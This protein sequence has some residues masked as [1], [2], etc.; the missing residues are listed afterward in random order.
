MLRPPPT[1]TLFPY[2]TLFRS[3]LFVG[4]MANF[5]M[6]APASRDLPWQHLSR[7]PEGAP[8][9]R[10]ALDLGQAWRALDAAKANA[11]IATLAAELPKINAGIYPS[12]RRSLELTYN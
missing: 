10:A 7:L 4:S 5:E 12:R 11:A 1:S 3:H 9:R 8:A 2:T 6:V